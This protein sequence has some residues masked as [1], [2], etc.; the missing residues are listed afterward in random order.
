MPTDTHDFQLEVIG[1]LLDGDDVL[2][3]IATGSGKTD[4]FIRLMHVIK[5]IASHPHTLGSVSFPRDPAMVIVCPTKALEEEMLRSSQE[6]KMRR[7][8]LTAIAL[9]SDTV[10]A[11]QQSGRDLFK[12]V[13]R[14]V[15]MVLVSPE[16]LKSKGFERLLDEKDPTFSTRVC[17]MAVDEAHL[18]NTWGQ[19][20]RKDFLDIG[21]MRARFPG[22]VPIAAVT[23]T[24]QTGTPTNRICTFLGFRPGCCQIIRRSNA[25]PDI[26]LIFRTMK[27]GLGSMVFPDLDWVVNSAERRRTLIFCRTV[28]LGFRV[29]AYLWNLLTNDPDRTKRL[30][31]F[32]AVNDKSYND[33]T[34]ALWQ[35]PN[36]AVQVIVATSILSVGIDAPTFDD[37]IVFGEPPDVDEFVQD[38]GRL[39][40]MK[41]VSPRAFLYVTKK[42]HTKAEKVVGNSKSPETKNTTTAD[43]DAMQPSIAQLILAPCKVVQL[44]E[45]YGN[46]L[47]E[48]PCGCL[49]CA[50]QPRPQRKATCDCSGCEPEPIPAEGNSNSS[51]SD[52]GD[53]SAGELEEPPVETDERAWNSK[54]SGVAGSDMGGG[55]L[56]C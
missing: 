4:M 55:G 7:A 18:L 33:E 20:F 56:P 1:Y 42:A 40:F 27:T 34:L 6:A 39:R 12:A 41:S 53:E 13:L 19:G 37:V 30:R 43:L 23:A 29:K 49:V 52:E 11:A 25:R 50:S 16:Q 14:G 9:N 54:A 15:S 46:M 2:L 38:Y 8:K 45:L 32:N 51:S 24:L 47:N 31:L 22:T 35:K 10:T 5:H 36:P 48:P 28:A 44:D 3:V 26:Q 17:M 21:R